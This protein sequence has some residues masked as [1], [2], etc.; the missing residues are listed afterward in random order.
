[1]TSYFI[2]ELDMQSSE[3]FEIEN[4]SLSFA[5]IEFQYLAINNIK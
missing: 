4:K 3:G 1:M 5:Y 2:V